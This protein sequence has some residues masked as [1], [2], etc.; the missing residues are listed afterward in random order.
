MIYPSVLQLCRAGKNANYVIADICSR[1]LF[2]LHFSIITP[3]NVRW[4][5]GFS[6]KKKEN[7]GG[8]KENMQHMMKC[9]SHN[10]LNPAVSFDRDN[11][12][13]M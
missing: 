10:V 3:P 5:C 9:K 12:E 1:P 6:C 8:K 2:Y 13:S 7:K 11:K 4:R